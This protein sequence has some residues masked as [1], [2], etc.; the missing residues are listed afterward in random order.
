MPKYKYTKILSKAQECKDSV[1][2]EYKLG[3][4]KKWSYYFAKAIIKPKTDITKI[5]FTKESD[6]TGTHISR[7]LTKAEYTDIA[8]R[9]IAYVEKH[10]K[11]P[12]YVTYKNYQIKIKLITYVFAKVLLHYKKDGKLPAEIN[13]NSK[14][15]T[16]PVEYK[17]EVYKYFVKKTGK[18]FKT[19]DDLLGYVKHNYSYQYYFDDKKSNKQVIDSESGNCTDLL[20][21]L[22]NMANEM[23]YESKCIHVKC[24]QSGTGHV[25]GKFKHKKNTADK[26]VVRD[27]A[28]VADGG[29]ITSVWCKDGYVLGENPSWFMSNLNR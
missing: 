16:K 20:Q 26:W 29:S 12:N 9:L 7:Q 15:F 5:D 1:K 11:L 28:S 2:K 19:I 24:R 3:I 8:K 10:K 6:P 27:I 23:G 18:E 4:N 14:I 17:N 22:I 13:I 25:F 21:F